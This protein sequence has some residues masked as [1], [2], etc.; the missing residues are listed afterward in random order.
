MNVRLACNI[1]CLAGLV[2]A[3]FSFLAALLTTIDKY[4]RNLYFSMIYNLHGVNMKKLSH[5]TH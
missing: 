1:D 2:A 3:K 5:S 4:I